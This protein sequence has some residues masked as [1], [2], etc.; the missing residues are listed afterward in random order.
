MSR[1]RA[2]PRARDGDD[3]DEV[4][5]RHVRLVCKYI[6][7]QGAAF[8]ETAIA[9]HA[10]ADGFAFLNDVGDDARDGGARDGG[11]R[12]RHRE[13]YVRERDAAIETYERARRA[14][15]EK[16]RAR[17]GEGE[18]DRDD[19]YADDDARDGEAL[20]SVMRARE[21]AERLFAGAPMEREPGTIV[22]DFERGVAE[23]RGGD[24]VEAATTTGKATAPAM[25]TVE[26]GEEDELVDDDFKALVNEFVVDDE[27]E[28]EDEDAPGARVTEA[29]ANANAETTATDAEPPEKEDDSG[30]VDGVE[31]GSNEEEP[32]MDLTMMFPSSKRRPVG[33]LGGFEQ[34]M[35]VKKK[36][37]PRK[38]KPKYEPTPSLLDDDLV[39]LPVAPLV[40]DNDHDNDEEEDDVAET[41][42]E[43]SPQVTEVPLEFLFPSSKPK[44]ALP[45]K[46]KND[47]EDDD[48]TQREP[49]L[50]VEVT[51]VIAHTEDVADTDADEGEVMQQ[52]PIKESEANPWDSITRAAVECNDAV[53]R[54]SPPEAAVFALPGRAVKLTEPEPESDGEETEVEEAEQT[55][56]EEEREDEV[57]MLPGKPVRIREVVTR[58]EPASDSTEREDAEPMF[59][60]PGKPVKPREEKN[61]SGSDVSSSLTVKGKDSVDKTNSIC[62]VESPAGGTRQKPKPPKVVAETLLARRV[63]QLIK[64]TLNVADLTKGQFKIILRKSMHK[65]TTTVPKKFDQNTE[66]GT[67]SFLSDSRKQKIN[68][69]LDEYVKRVKLRAASKNS[70]PTTPSPFEEAKKVASKVA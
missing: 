63:L 11:A 3:D 37:G 55:E 59:C 25:A 61:P 68:R 53:V 27:D 35:R 29:E 66:E 12:A 39:A 8:E 21:I 7:R 30:H 9:R 62:N 14:A 64:S 67:T 6:A 22:I 56:E 41:D 58:D 26:L 33:D 49:V 4:V 15:E 43:D 60:L 34:V 17:E 47:D 23:T 51:E 69:L 44:R 48:V 36:R 52:T 24:A 70:T 1:D 45:E 18:R 38:P 2:R 32:E 13:M 50:A 28:N 5:A 57:F 65:I 46:K 42:V 16:E 54:E 20:A 10:R 40:D 31:D 19:G